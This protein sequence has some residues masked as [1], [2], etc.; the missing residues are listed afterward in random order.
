MVDV[1]AM[2]EKEL[3]ALRQKIDERSA[4][5]K[6]TK[7]KDQLKHLLPLFRKAST[8][9]EL[10]VQVTFNLKALINWEDECVN[11]YYDF[12]NEERVWPYSGGHD[13]NDF[14]RWCGVDIEERASVLVKE[15]ENDV[16]ELESK[17]KSLNKGD[18]WDLINKL[19]EMGADE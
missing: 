1:N 5:M 14:L 17:L 10:D 3:N 15:K 16:S 8:D 13:T 7:L 18:P 12:P 19:F 4:K 11:L 9:V 2:C 6:N